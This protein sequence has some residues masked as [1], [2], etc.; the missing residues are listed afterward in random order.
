M[1][2]F[3]ISRH[4]GALEWLKN[5]GIVVDKMLPHLD[6]DIIQPNDTVI[7]NLPIHLAAQVCEKKARYFHLEISI[8]LQYRGKEL[9][10]HQLTELGA[11][12]TQF[13]IRKKIDS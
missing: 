1:P 10:A 8:P 7:G 9:T 13:Y 6:I 5:Q 12:L 2:S 3:F 4:S 11:K